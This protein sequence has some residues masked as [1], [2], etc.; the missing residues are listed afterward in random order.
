MKTPSRYQNI[1]HLIFPLTKELED[2]WLEYLDDER[3]L[4][5]GDMKDSRA[6]DEKELS[7]KYRSL[8][9]EVEADIFCIVN[10]GNV[11][12]VLHKITETLSVL[13]NLTVEMSCGVTE[14]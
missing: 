2:A 13:Q 14:L 6:K 3:D 7:R 4:F 9:D 12:G 8:I 5:F 10:K 11:W 1:R